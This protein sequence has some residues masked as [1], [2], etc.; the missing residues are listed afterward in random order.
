EKRAEAAARTGDAFGS[1]QLYRDV[2]ERWHYRG[3]G[4]MAEDVARRA[5]ELWR[6]M[7]QGDEALSAGLVV[8]RMRNQ[9][10]G[11]SGD[12]LTA[13]LADRVRLL[14]A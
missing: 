8:V 10:P 6:Q 13:V 9:M 7:P 2:A 5:E 11:Q 3:E 4:A 14:Q 1:I 12:A